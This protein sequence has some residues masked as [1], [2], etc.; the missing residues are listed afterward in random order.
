MLLE[1]SLRITLFLLVFIVFAL[2]NAL[3]EKLNIIRSLKRIFFNSKFLNGN[4]K[5]M[6][7]KEGRDQSFN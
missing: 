1:F 6:N 5:K 7:H 2:H 4:E 3:G